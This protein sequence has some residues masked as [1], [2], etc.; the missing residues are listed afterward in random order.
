MRRHWHHGTEPLSRRETCAPDIFPSASPLL[1]H[2]RQSRNGRYETLQL[3]FSN[4]RENAYSTHYTDEDFY[5]FVFKS[6][7]SY[8]Q[9]STLIDMLGSERKI[10]AI[11]TVT[12]YFPAKIFLKIRW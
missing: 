3:A 9:L 5:L 8:R 4:A 10:D 1:L 6:H 11:E 7:F 12:S 2:Q